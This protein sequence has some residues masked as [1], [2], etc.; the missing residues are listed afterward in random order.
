MQPLQH[1]NELQTAVCRS[2]VLGHL[3]SMRVIE[4]M[5]G[6][7]GGE[8]TGV[9][10]IRCYMLHLMSTKVLSEATV[11]CGVDDRLL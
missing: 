4:M 2:I 7:A 1:H 10:I 6:Q 8:T 11:S 3:L 9:T 5:N